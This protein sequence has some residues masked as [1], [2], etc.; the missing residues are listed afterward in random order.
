MRS[1]IVHLRD[2]T[3]QEVAGFLQRTYPFQ[4]GPPW[5]AH[6]AGDACLYIDFYRDGPS[7]HEPKEW[8]GI[9][10]S[11]GGEPSVSVGA[12]VS[13]RH[14]G[15]EQVRDFVGA[16]LGRFGGAA[17]DDYTNHL[18]SLEEIVTGHHVQGHAFFDYLGWYADEN[19]DA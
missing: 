11:F 2:T 12:D 8:A 4:Q 17:Q 9:L 18:W 10:A 15:D 5:I 7:E 14:P 6:V 3:E 13:G 1:V 16:L 19:L